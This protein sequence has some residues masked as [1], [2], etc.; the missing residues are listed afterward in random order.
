MWSE[1]ANRNKLLKVAKIFD[2]KPRR[3]SVCIGRRKK[4]QSSG[5]WQAFEATVAAFTS[6]SALAGGQNWHGYYR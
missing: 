3:E 6:E 5:N 1:A 2:H 4:K